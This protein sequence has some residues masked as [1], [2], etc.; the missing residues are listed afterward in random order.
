MA[1]FEAMSCH[2][3]CWREWQY[4]Q[5]FVELFNRYAADAVLD[6]D[7]G[8]SYLDPKGEVIEHQVRIRVVPVAQ[9][10]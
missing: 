4:R 7:G 10:T 6:V 3:D 9:P 2:P 1:N 8:I 5:R